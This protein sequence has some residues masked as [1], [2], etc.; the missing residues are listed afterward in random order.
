MADDDGRPRC[1]GA[2]ARRAEYLSDIA[3][4]VE[5]LIDFGRAS[6]RFGGLA[7]AQSGARQNAQITGDVFAYP[8]GDS[9]RVFFPT[10]R[11][12]AFAIRPRIFG[13]GVTPQE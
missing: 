13:L 5:T 10:L 6:E 3:S 11:Q 7:A 8:S 2:P 4:G 9:A 1:L 12:S